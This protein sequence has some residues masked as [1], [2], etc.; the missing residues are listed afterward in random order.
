MIGW[1]LA[2]GLGVAGGVFLA[3]RGGQG[4]SDGLDGLGAARDLEMREVDLGGKHE[5]MFEL[6][7]DGRRVAAIM[8]VRKKI[9]GK[10]RYVIRGVNVLTENRRNG[11]A[12]MLYEKAATEACRRRAPLA[13]DERVGSMS[14]KFW[15][16]QIR[17]GRAEVLSKRGGSENGQK[18]EVFSLRCP[19]ESLRGIL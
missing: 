3:I 9:S 17:K 15:E 16:K 7:S 12:T 1:S 2:V 4:S 6:L 11:L 19:M 14:R 13:S 18:S 10:V 5:F 8:A